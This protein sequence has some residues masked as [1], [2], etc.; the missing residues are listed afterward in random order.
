[1]ARIGIKDYLRVEG[2]TKTF[3]STSVKEKGFQ[4]SLRVLDN[5][6]FSCKAGEFITV[7]GPNGCGKTTIFR[8][9]AGLEDQEYG[10]ITIGGKPS[11]ESKIGYIF[12][13]YRESLYPWRTCFDN[14]RVP[15]ELNKVPRRE[16]KKR[17]EQFLFNLDFKV[18]DDAYPYQLSGGQQ[19]LLCILRALLYEPDVLLMDEPFS[20]LD[21]QTTLYMHDKVLE[22][23]GKMKT[24]ILF[25][26]HDINEAVYLADKVVVLSKRPAHVMDVIE[27]D[28]PRPR[29]LEMTESEEFFAVRNRVLDI[30]KDEIADSLIRMEMSG[31]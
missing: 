5:V 22:I 9:M 18:Q 12:Q 14:L 26:S 17:I 23:W 19:Q 2:L 6:N 25:I 11:Y 30:F 4:G 7:V 3:S 20:S 21:F 13:N 16:R 29:K 15:L 1:M 27:V 31:F 10:R 24:T 8:I 28:L